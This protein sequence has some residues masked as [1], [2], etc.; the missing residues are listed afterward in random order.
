MLPRFYS[1]GKFLKIYTFKNKKLQL[2]ETYYLLELR[3]RMREI[4]SKHTVFNK[5]EEILKLFL[6]A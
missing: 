2:K 3:L 1:L 6:S 5:K 4:T